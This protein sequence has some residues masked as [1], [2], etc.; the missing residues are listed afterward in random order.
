MIA[1]GNHLDYGFAAR[2]TTLEGEA[3]WQT[4]IPVSIEQT[5]SDYGQGFS[6]RGEAVSPRLFGT[7]G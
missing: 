2:S 6:P 3:F 5:A 1:T 7:G 4:T